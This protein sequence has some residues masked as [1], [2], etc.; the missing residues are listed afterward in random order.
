[1]KLLRSNRL[2]LTCSIVAIGLAPVLVSTSALGCQVLQ[3]TLVSWEDSDYNGSGVSVPPDLANVVLFGLDQVSNSAVAITA[4]GEVVEWGNYTPFPNKPSNLVGARAIA[5]GFGHALALKSDGTVMAWGN[6][7]HGGTD[8]PAGLSGVVALS[9]SYHD[10][11]LKS[12]G[13]V[14]AWGANWEGQAEVPV[15]LAKVVAVA[16]GVDHSLALKSDGTVVAW[17]AN[18][19]GQTDVPTGLSHVVAVAAGRVHSLA[20]KSDGTVVAWGVNYLGVTDVPVGLSGVVAVAAGD[21]TSLALKSDGTVVQ[22]GSV[23]WGRSPSVPMGLKASAIAAGSESYSLA[24][25][26]SKT[27]GSPDFVGFLPPLGGADSTGGTY[28]SPLRTLKAGSTIPVK[29][30]QTCDGSSVVLPGV[31]TLQ[32]VKWSDS[33][34]AGAPIDATPG[35]AASTGDQFRLTGDEWHFNLDTK[36]T[37]MSAG[38][39]Q[40]IATLADGTQHTAWIQLK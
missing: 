28:E 8:V 21:C 3:G 35:E 32:V 23:Q 12:D 25:V 29:F 5:V 17:G 24:L 20:L 19:A 10:L 37:G 13:T 15:G 31:N 36:A 2:A 11:A 14:V 4:T 26:A 7:W 16:A 38:R 30:Q 1:M 34:T 18:W 33:T 22:W 6:N 39:W 27:V 9:A 40:L